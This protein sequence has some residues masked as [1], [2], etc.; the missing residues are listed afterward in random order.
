[1]KAERESEHL[2]VLIRRASIERRVRQLAR[3]ITTDFRGDRVHLIGVLKG[4]SIFLSD[5]I[6]DIGLEV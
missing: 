5:L 2:R 6:R 1:M 4:A 3:K